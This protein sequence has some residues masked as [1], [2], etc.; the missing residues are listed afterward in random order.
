MARTFTIEDFYQEIE[1]KEEDFKVLK[2]KLDI[3]ERILER[4]FIEHS[5]VMFIAEKYTSCWDDLKRYHSSNTLTRILFKRNIK[6]AYKEVCK[7]L[8]C[9]EIPDIKITLEYYLNTYNRLKR[10]KKE[11][12]IARYRFNL[13]LECY[14]DFIDTL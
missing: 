5:R 1:D 2:L 7:R 4:N 11:I 12:E 14:S 3:K 10:I 13:A 8:H 6:K 9:E